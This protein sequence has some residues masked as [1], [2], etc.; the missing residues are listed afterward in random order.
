MDR[1]HRKSRSVW[2]SQTPILYSIQSE[3]IKHVWY[4]EPILEHIFIC[5]IL[6]ICCLLAT[7]RPFLLEFVEIGT[8]LKSGNV[9]SSFVQC[10]MVSFSSV[11][12]T[13]S[14]SVWCLVGLHDIL[15]AIVMRISTVKTVLWLAVNL[16]HL[17]SNGAAFNTQSRSSLTS[18]A[19]R[20]QNRRWIACDSEHDIA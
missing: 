16:H 7:K 18:Y 13:K 1:F 10:I 5:Q 17:F 9:W 14:E 20:A 3:D 12:A 4:F 2:W 8:T 15:H 11:T 6:F 19:I